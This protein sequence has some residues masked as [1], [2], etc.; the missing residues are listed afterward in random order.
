VGPSGGKAE[1]IGLKLLVQPE[2]GVAV[3]L[4]GIHNAKRT[5]E[6]AI[7]RLDHKRIEEE[8]EAAAKRRVF[9]RALVAFHNRGGEQ[10]LRR[11]E[12]RFLASG[13][14]V[15]RT[16]DDLVKYHAKI[17]II[18]RT[19]LYVLSYNYTA[20]DAEHSRGFGIVTR[21]RGLVQEAVKLFE[22]DT[23]RQ[24]YVPQLN[25]FLV[26]PLNARKRLSEFIRKARKELL[27]YDPK[28]SDS[29]MINL[30]V[31]RQKA[32]IEIK[33]LGRLGKGGGTLNSR[34]LTTIRLHTRAIIRDRKHAFVGSQSLR[35]LELDARRE[36]GVIIKNPQ[37]I[38]KLAATFESDWA[39]NQG[40]ES[41]ADIDRRKGK[42][43]TKIAKKLNP[44]SAEIKRAVKK[45]VIATGEQ[46]ITDQETKETLKQAVKKT[47]KEAFKEAVQETAERV[48]NNT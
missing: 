33:I 47:V 12:S 2:D 9:V 37:V 20:L 29:Q 31:E 32:G 8:I 17:L 36:V 27:I 3:I 5:V 22:A 7:F 14:T 28:I 40:K 44:L 19:T 41:R 13:V 46:V 43:A 4:A 24:P 42:N 16:N 48:E 34:K 26:S 38:G 23:K 30:L 10:Q 25:T 15:T 45:V 21:N 6:I 11:L 39:A 1:D 35:K 18:D